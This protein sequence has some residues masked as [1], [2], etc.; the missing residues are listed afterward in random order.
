MIDRATRQRA[1]LCV[2]AASA[3]YTVAAALVKSLAADY[4]AVEMMFFRSLVVAAVTLPIQLRAGGWRALR[5]RKPM[6]HVWR[7]VFGFTGMLTAYYGYGHLPLATNTA[8]GF[9]M[10]LFLTILSVPLLGERVGWK[11]VLAVLAGLG[12]VLLMVRPWAS[13]ADAL[14]PLPVAIVMAGVVTWALAM[15]S[16]R[17]MGE[18]GESNVAIV[19]WFG[20]GSA[21][22]A[23]ALSLPVWVTPTWLALGGLLAIGI[24]T[25]IAQLLMTEAY[26]IGETTLV[27]P[28]EYGAIVYSTLLGALIWHELPNAWG[29]T[30]IAIIIAAGL[31]VWHQEVRGKPGSR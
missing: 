8:L 28:F 9:C 22:L 10:P 7:L 5:P 20:V 29:F 23:G 25:L 27:A 14:P 31:M 1:I 16:I 21:V 17:R 6:S 24:V 30:G 11:R 4:P 3:L 26:R 2:M 19:L 15:I 13:G 18:Q 12:G